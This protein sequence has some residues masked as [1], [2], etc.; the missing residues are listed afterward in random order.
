M[1]KPFFAPLPRH[2]S[3]LQSPCALS[4][5]Q[6][7]CV[8]Y[9]HFLPFFVRLIFFAPLS[10]CSFPD[11][12]IMIPSYCLGGAIRWVSKSHV[13]F[14]H[15]KFASLSC[16]TILKA[17][18]PRRVR[19]APVHGAIHRWSWSSLGRLLEPGPRHPKPWSTS[20]RGSDEC[21]FTESK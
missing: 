21:I 6:P 16:L 13:L 9:H 15:T 17:C 18:D 4:N 19:R 12:N 2:W 3:I 1:H 20:H 14:C 5:G 10:M 11:T 7:W 8:L